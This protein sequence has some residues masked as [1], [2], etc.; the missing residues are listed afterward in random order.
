ML[1]SFTK[2]FH[3]KNKGTN[4]GSMDGQGHAL[5]RSEFEALKEVGPKRWISTGEEDIEDLCEEIVG[6]FAKIRHM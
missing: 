1:R 3:F 5:L 6:N 2:F 4:T